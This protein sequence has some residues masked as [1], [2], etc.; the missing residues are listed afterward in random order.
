MHAIEHFG[1]GRY[2]DPIDVDGHNKGVH[3]LID[4]TEVGGRLYLSFPIGRADEVQF[5]EQRVFHPNWILRHPGIAQTMKLVRF[6]YV[7]DQGDLHLDC[8]I[9]GKALDLDYGCGIFTFEKLR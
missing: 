8:A 9:E 7:D 4:L 3:N 6:D 5:N 2:F 1:L